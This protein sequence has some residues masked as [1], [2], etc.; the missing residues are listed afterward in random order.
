MAGFGGLGINRAV[1]AYPVYGVDSRNWAHVI[2]PDII[3]Q[4][5]IENWDGGESWTEIPGLTKLVTNNGNLLFRSNVAGIEQDLPLVT[6]V[7]FCPM[8]PSLVLIGTSEGGIFSSSDLGKTWRKFVDT[9]AAASDIDRP[10][11]ITS[12]F[13]ETQNSVF[14]ST[15]GR[16]LWQLRNVRVAVADAFDLSATDF[17]AGASYEVLVDD[18]PVKDSVTAGGSGSFTTRLTAPSEPGSHSVAVRM[19]GSEKVIDRSTVLVRN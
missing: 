1:A 4:L 16:G 12:F 5:M 17:V 2:A 18:V 11:Y 13:W 19:V 8:D 7:S 6:A 15:F 3:N 14:V 9:N 10:T